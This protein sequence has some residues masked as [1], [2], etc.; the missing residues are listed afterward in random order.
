MTDLYPENKRIQ[1][2]LFNIFRSISKKYGYEEIEPPILESAEIYKKSGQEI[3]EQMYSFKD[4]S[5]RL[6]ALRPE[7][8]PSIARMINNKSLSLPI[9]WFSISRCFRYERTQA[10]R[11]K[12]F[13]QYNIDMIGSTSMQADAEIIKTLVEILKSLKLTKKDF[14]IRISNRKLIDDLLKSINIT[15]IKQVSQLI[16]KKDKLQEKDFKLALKDLKLT[17]KQIQDLLKIIK[18]SSLDKIKIESSGLTE[19]K[20]LFSYLK[21]YNILDYCKLDLSIMRGFDYYTSTVF[22]A[23]DTKK[24]FR[25]IA[26]GGRYDNLASFPGVGYGFGDR[27]IL[28]LLENK[29]P[30]LE[31]QVDYYIAPVNKKIIPKAIQ[32]AE[33]L[34]KTSTVELDLLNRNLSKQIK[35]ASLITNNLIIVGEKDIKNKKVTL[36]DLKTGKEK[37]ILISRL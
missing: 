31:K 30:K 19:L 2:Y 17:N 15:N 32:I 1:N 4:K 6:L 28:L 36:R 26:G 23:F 25:A 12:E 8:T 18:I 34:R 16:D 9:K 29:L 5:S 3:P 7:T 10:G 22:E 14:F 13:D 24:Q 11:S 35:Y 27:V 20:E 21:S 33:K 37:K